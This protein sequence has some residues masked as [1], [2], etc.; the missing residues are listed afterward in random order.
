MCEACG[1]SGL[2]HTRD[3]KR[4]ERVYRCFCPRGEQYATPMFSPSD[5]K[6]ERPMIM[7]RF[8]RPPHDFKKDAAGDK[9]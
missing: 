9:D 6:K 7:P 8:P 5:K 4:V 2:I 3:A 1:N